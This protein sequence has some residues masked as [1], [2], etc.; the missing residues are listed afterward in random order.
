M[1][2]H[3]RVRKHNFAVEEIGIWMHGRMMERKIDLLIPSSLYEDLTDWWNQSATF[4]LTFHTI[5]PPALTANTRTLEATVLVPYA[6]SRWELHCLHSSICP[7]TK[8]KRRR[9]GE[10]AGGERNTKE[11]S[12]VEKRDTS[13]YQSQPWLKSKHIFMHCSI[14]Y[15][16]IYGVI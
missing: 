6:E 3:K 12:G 13:C 2:L 8:V 7:G 1:F 4:C 14:W 16:H 9:L 15:F 11:Q 10:R 5:T